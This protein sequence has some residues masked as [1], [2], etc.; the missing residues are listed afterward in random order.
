VTRLAVIA[1]AVA[2]TT[3]L[4]ATAVVVAGLREFC[5]LADDDLFDT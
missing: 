3:V 1:A 4:A 5:R 2:V